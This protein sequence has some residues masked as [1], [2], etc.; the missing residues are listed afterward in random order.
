MKSVRAL[1]QH[2]CLTIIA[3]CCVLYSVQTLLLSPHADRHGGHISVTDFCFCFVFVCLLVRRN[4]V[5][6][7]SGVGWHRAMKFCRMVD[8][9][10]H[11]VSSPVSELW[12]CRS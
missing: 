4:L 11:Q 1:M 9:G 7:I 12:P 3:M 5:T 2:A 8:L 6:D 10:V